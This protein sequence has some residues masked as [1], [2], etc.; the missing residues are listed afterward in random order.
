[1]MR[2][3]SQYRTDVISPVGA[4]GFMQL[5]PHTARQVAKLLDDGTYRERQLIG[6]EVNIRLG[7]RYLQ[8]LLRKFENPIPLAAAGYNAGPHRVE[9]WL[10]AFG[11]LDMDEFIEHI[12]FVETRNYVKKVV[13]NFGIYRDLYG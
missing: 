9:S 7:T 8:R 13:R 10:S 3:E 4:R 2:A 1:I 12:P 6:P 5:M 11:N